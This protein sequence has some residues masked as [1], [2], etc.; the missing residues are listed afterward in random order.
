T[1]AGVQIDALVEI[2]VGMQ[3]CGV[4]PGEPASDLAKRIGD[5][6]GLRFRGLQAYHGT[7]QHLPTWRER[8]AA[9]EAAAQAVRTTLEALERSGVQCDVVSGAGTGTFRCEGTSGVWNELH[10]RSYVC[11]DT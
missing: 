2:D 10:A 5:A 6:K 9:I 3:R 1:E 7:A 4:A 8:E 11:R